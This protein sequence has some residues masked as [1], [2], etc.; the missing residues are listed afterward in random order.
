MLAVEVV[1][2]VPTVQLLM[3]FL[4]DLA[5]LVV[6]ELVVVVAEMVL[7]VQLIPVAVVV[8]VAIIIRLVQVQTVAQV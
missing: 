2:P 7:L 8:V 5:G 1:V 6:A 3:L 4:E